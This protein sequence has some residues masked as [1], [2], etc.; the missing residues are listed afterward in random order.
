MI[1]ESLI[2]MSRRKLEKD[3]DGSTMSLQAD[4]AA[5]AAPKH[6]GLEVM[7]RQMLDNQA[8]MAASIRELRQEIKVLKE[9]T[10]P[11]NSVSI[12]QPAV[13]DSEKVPNDDAVSVLNQPTRSHAVEI[14]TSM[15]VQVA[16]VER[17]ESSDSDAP[18]DYIASLR[19][20]E[21]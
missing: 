3:E 2:Q 6:N 11:L 7:M 18:R 13:P 20:H 10:L 1:C 5:A 19:D 15:E 12:A 4:A 21:S 14:E 9:R 16:Q 17:T 8:E